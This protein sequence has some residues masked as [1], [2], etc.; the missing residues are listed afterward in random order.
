MDVPETAMV[1]AAGQGKRMRPLSATTPK[2]LV[3]VG[4]RALID[5]CLD[6]LAAVG[7]K[8]RGRQRPPSRRSRRGASQESQRRRG[9]SS[10]T[11]A[12]RCSKRAA[13][14]ARALPL[15]G[16]RPFLLRNSDSFWLDGVRPNLAWLAGGWDDERMDGLLLLAST[17]RSI[18]Y[19]GRG[20]FLLDKDRPADAPPGAHGGALRLCRRRHPLA[21]PFR[22]CARWGVLAEPPLRSCH[23]RAVGCSACGI[24][25]LWINVETPQAIA[26][27]D[28]GDRGERRVKRDGSAE[29]LHHPGRRAVPR[30][31]GRG[32]A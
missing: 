4:G 3:K 7:V 28:R 24:D 25:G 14:S 20:D 23:R 1:L 16:D 2:P 27:A 15:L 31:A 26:V 22:R 12:T 17:V 11:S 18:G 30:H 13:A 6:G 9:S 19:S 10:P 21:A 8:T 29:R 32:A 5:H